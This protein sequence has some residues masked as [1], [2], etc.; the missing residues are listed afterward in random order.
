MKQAIGR[1]LAF[2]VARHFPAEEP[3][4]HGVSGIAADRRDA[5]VTAMYQHAAGIVAITRTGREHYLIDDRAAHSQGL[6][7]QVSR[8]AALL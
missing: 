6:L 5:P 2:E 8:Q 3:A 7:P 1:I 4:C